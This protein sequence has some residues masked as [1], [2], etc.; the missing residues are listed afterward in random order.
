MKK[1]CTKCKRG[2]GSELDGLCT[3]C[4]GRTAWDQRVKDGTLTKVPDDHAVTKVWQ[5]L[6]K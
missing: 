4:R 1:P 2:Y 3:H 6:M 5:G